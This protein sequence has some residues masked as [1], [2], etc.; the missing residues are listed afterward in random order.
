MPM[1]LSVYVR[2]HDVTVCWTAP[3]TQTNSTAVSTKLTYC[4][5]ISYLFLYWLFESKFLY[6]TLSANLQA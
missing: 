6:E 2:V 3:T 5:S 4:L 1:A